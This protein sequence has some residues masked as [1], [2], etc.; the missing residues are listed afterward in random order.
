MNVL[1]TLNSGLGADLGPNFSLTADS[2]TVAP[3]TATKAELLAGITVS[4]D[5]AATSVSVTSTGN[6]TNT[7]T[8]PIT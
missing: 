8:I 7:L 5:G 3:L 1:I 2:G 4:V 6:C